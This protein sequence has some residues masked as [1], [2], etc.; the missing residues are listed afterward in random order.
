MIHFFPFYD[1]DFSCTPLGVAL[2]AQGVESKFFA[3]T[4]NRRHKTRFQL[5]VFLWPKLIFASFLTGIQSLA[6]S[7]KPHLMVADT[8]FQALIFR[9]LLKV[10]FNKHTKILLMGF[11][12]NIRDDK[13]IESIR[14]AY[15]T[16]ALKC[17]DLVVCHSH[18]EITNYA[19]Y[20]KLPTY[21]FSFM[22]WASTV[23][24]VGSAMPSPSAR[25]FIFSAG[26]SWRD[27]NILIDAVKGLD[28]ELRI[29]CDSL[30]VLPDVDYP[31]NVV[32]LRDCYAESYH[33]HLAHSIF[34]VLPLNAS[35][36]S[37]GQMVLIDAY[38]YS[39]AV[40]CT[41]TVTV[42]DYLADG[43]SGVLVAM[44]NVDSMRAAIVRLLNDPP[45]T[46]ALGQ[47]AHEFYKANFT[48]D[49]KVKSLA[50][51]LDQLSVQ[52]QYPSGS[53]SSE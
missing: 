18:E 51:L 42:R 35:T 25:P 29:A 11:I 39:R 46:A 30:S 14:K 3:Y 4:I 53:S 6:Q 38:A 8:H 20:F 21:R 31:E 1:A 36:I 32:V 19:R 9:L 50:R 27:Y 37:A 45:F 16:V 2:R 34:C 17:C 28:I 12:Y 7:R 5:I 48:D 44:K 52:T 41:D 13:F 23:H 26:R 15:G 47:S 49:A 24:L 10:F 33:Q 43:V 22:A 40:V